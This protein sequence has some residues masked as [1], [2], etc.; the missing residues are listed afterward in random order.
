MGFYNSQSEANYIFLTT[1][2]K[3]D[4]S[5][6]TPSGLTTK[7]MSLLSRKVELVCKE[8]VVLCR[9]GKEK[10]RKFDIK[11]LDEGYVTVLKGLPEVIPLH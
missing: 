8:T 9:W 6:K 4:T 3:K 11:Q 5:T 2:N 7:I 1:I 10:T